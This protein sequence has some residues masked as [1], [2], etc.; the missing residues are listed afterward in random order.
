MPDPIETMKA[1][2][3]ALEKERADLQRRIQ[4]NQ[5]AQQQLVNALIGA[6][7]SHQTLCAL[8]AE[9]EKKDETPTT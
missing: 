5:Q 7:H 2:I 3:N 9:L 6:E 8:V 1:K 4:L